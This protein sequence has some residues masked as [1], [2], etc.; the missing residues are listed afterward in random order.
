MSQTYIKELLRQNQTV[1]SFQEL[2]LFSKDG[3]IDALKSRL[4]YYVKRG[5]LYHIRRGL[6]AKDKNYNRFELAT[7]IYTPSYISL[8][9]VL[10]QAAINF[11]YYTEIFVVTYQTKSLIID[12]QTYTFRTLKRS[13]LANPKGIDIKDT[14]SIASPERA[15]LDVIYLQKH[16][17]FDDLYP[18]NWEKVYKILPI[19]GGHK[20]MEK[21]VTMYHNDYKQKYKKRK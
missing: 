15:F 19:Y 1:F 5:D 7:K 17:H 9:T 8:E 4:N 13:I 10:I 18:L 3:N 12:E 2:L 14:Y 16:Y 20:R 6:Y 11:Q 21:M